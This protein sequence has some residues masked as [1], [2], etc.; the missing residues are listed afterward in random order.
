MLSRRGT[1]EKPPD[2]KGTSYSKDYFFSSV[3]DCCWCSETTMMMPPIRGA[4]KTTTTMGCC[5]CCWSSSSFITS[6]TQHASSNWK[7][8]AFGV[9]IFY[10]LRGTR[11]D[12]LWK[13]KKTNTKKRSAAPSISGQKTTTESSY[14]GVLPGDLFV[15]LGLRAVPE[16]GADRCAHLF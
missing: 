13:K 4:K 7:K 2:Q 11:Q 6:F 14:L 3:P 9:E 5:C 16:R 12:R 8:R 15:E 10:A 1:T